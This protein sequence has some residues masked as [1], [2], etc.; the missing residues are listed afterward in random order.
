MK[1][2]EVDTITILTNECIKVLKQLRPVNKF[3]NPILKER[4]HIVYTLEYN[5][6]RTIVVRFAHA[7]KSQYGD[8]FNWDEF[9]DKCKE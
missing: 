7:F 5:D 6:W 4:A 8:K 2:T 9:I 3:A 1:N